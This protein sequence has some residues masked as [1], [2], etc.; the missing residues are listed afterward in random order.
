MGFSNKE[1]TRCICG[2]YILVEN[3]NRYTHLRSERH[4]KYINRYFIFNSHLKK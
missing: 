2:A 4:V 1:R 3:L